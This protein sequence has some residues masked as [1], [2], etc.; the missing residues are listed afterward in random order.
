M[1]TYLRQLCNWFGSG[2]ALPCR[3][4][5]AITDD[6]SG[7]TTRAR[8]EGVVFGITPWKWVIRK[9]FDGLV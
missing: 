1:Q 5:G 4:V 3:S 9:C 2:D 8:A 7:G 6:F